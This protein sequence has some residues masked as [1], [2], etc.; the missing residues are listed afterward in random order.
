MKS[1]NNTATIKSARRDSTARHDRRQV[2][3]LNATAPSPASLQ[4]TSW[5][6]GGNVDITA[7]QATIGELAAYVGNSN[8]SVVFAR[9]ASVVAGAY[10]GSQIDRSSA[11]SVISKFQDE[12]KQ[13]SSSGLAAQTCGLSNSTIG[14]QYFGIVYVGSSDV[15]AVQ[16]ALLSWDGAQCVMGNDVQPWSGVQVNMISGNDVSITSASEARAKLRRRSMVLRPRDTCKYTQ[17]MTTNTMR[18]CEQY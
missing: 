18:L 15:T 11:S 3:S 17:G 8:E 5:N 16:K 12:I 13:K 6:D 10:I 14:P 1:Q 2:L 4:L 9:T 7:A